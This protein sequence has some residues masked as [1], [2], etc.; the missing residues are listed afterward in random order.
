MNPD[1][2]WFL[3]NWGAARILSHLDQ[4]Q[5]SYVRNFGMTP[6]DALKKA[7]AAF[8]MNPYQ[9]WSLCHVGAEFR[10]RRA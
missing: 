4:I 9:Y 5:S 2:K 7:L 3:E 6:R 10:E 8:N 1:F